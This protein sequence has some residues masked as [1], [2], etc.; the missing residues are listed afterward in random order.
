MPIKEA[1]PALGASGGHWNCRCDGDNLTVTPNEAPEQINFPARAATVTAEFDAEIARAL[2][3]SHWRTAA[4]F[5]HLTAKY[6]EAGDYLSLD[7]NRRQ[8]REQF[9]EGNS[10]YKQLQEARA[11]AAAWIGAEA[12]RDIEP[13]DRGRRAAEVAGMSVLPID[14]AARP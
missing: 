12:F 8:A 6:A 10:V 11:A 14:S 5:L 3:A 4:L 1:P 9:L 13:I 7:R 2:A